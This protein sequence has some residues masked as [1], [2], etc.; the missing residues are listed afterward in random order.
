[1]SDGISDERLRGMGWDHIAQ[2]MA[3]ELQ[4]ALTENTELRKALSE[5]LHWI[6]PTEAHHQHRADHF[7]DEARIGFK[8]IGEPNPFED[9]RE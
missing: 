8:L 1:M 9:G 2:A 7:T 6:Y 5:L 3:L 4:K